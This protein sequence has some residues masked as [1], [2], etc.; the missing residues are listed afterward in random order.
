M[1]K[2]TSEITVSHHYPNLGEALKCER[3]EW[4]LSISHLYLKP[5][6]RSEKLGK[7]VK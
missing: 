6:V 1:V 3:T 5:G 4:R 7:A 2:R